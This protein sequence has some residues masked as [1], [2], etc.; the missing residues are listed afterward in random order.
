[1]GVQNYAGF[2]SPEVDRAIE[3]SAAVESLFERR[4][5]LERIMQ[6]LMDE[7]VWVPLYVDQDVYGIDRGFSWQPRSDSFVLAAEISPREGR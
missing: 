4:A 5:A 6:M 3:E 7:L 1:V 2:A